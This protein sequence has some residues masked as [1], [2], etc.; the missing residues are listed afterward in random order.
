MSLAAVAVG[1]SAAG[2]GISAMGAIQGGKAQ[3]ASLAY[4]AQVNR[5]NAII[6]EDNAEYAIKAGQQ[7]AA[8]ESMKGAAALGAVKAAQAASGV[9]V[10]TGS[11]VD[12]QRSEREKSKLDVE[13]VIHNAELRAYGYRSQAA[14][15]E[16]QAALNEAEGAQAE[17]AGYIK[18]LGTVL[19]GAGSAAG[20]WA[21]LDSGPSVPTWSSNS[22]SYNWSNTG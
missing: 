18:G 6:A 5:N 13:T 22:G 10:N 11:N 9:N 17:K 7:K 15:F 8:T 1:L 4:Q 3:K 2:T 16:A 12:V 21:K 14:N 20:A 19:S